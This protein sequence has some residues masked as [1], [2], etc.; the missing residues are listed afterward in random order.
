[1]K[2]YFIVY[3]VVHEVPEVPYSYDDFVSTV[4]VSSISNGTS[5][6]KHFKERTT[7]IHL[8]VFMFI[9]AAAPKVLCVVDFMNSF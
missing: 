6:D 1:M 4:A 8:A 7:G 9:G 2:Y 5:S 3:V